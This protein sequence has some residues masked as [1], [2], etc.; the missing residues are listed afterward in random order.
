MSEVIVRGGVIVTVD[1]DSNIVSG[2]VAAIDGE[3]V[4][5][6][7]EYTPR[8]RDYEILDAEG[9]AV[10]PGLVQSHTHLCQTL[11]RGAGDDLAL[12]DWLRK[13]VWPYEASLEAEDLAAAARLACAELLLGGTTAILDMGTVRHTDQVFASCQAAGIRA[14]IG[15]VMMDETTG[16]IP[17]PMRES[18]QAS[19][20]ESIRLC[21]AWHGRANGRLR[22]AFTPRF[23]LSCTEE[24]LRDTAA[25][26]RRRGCRLHTHSSENQSELEEV[27]RRT[28]RRN[29]SY[30]HDVGFTGAD[31]GLAHCIWLDDDET[32][33]LRDTGTHVLHCPSSNLKLGSG[34]APIP[35]L[36]AAGVSVSIGADG[37]PCNNN[38]DAFL[39]M[40]LSALIHKPRA[41]T[42]AMPA[43]LVLK[44]ATLGGARA[45]GLEDSIGS[46]EVGKRAD[47]IA[48]SMQGA[49]VAP[50]EDPYS[51][52]VYAARSADVRHV[53][54]DGAVA[55]RDRELLTID[56]DAVIEEA[57]QRTPHI[58][59]RA[60]TLVASA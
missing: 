46:L 47:L 59:R 60:K 45:L 38:L 52:I 11:A 29:L 58:M 34:I 17:A 6:G 3:L 30:L 2:D 1:P 48:V 20:D 14:T 7:G 21:E 35:E 40:R 27:V 8:T 32:R 33:I 26:A 44:M 55:V 57:R 41:G 39:E 25:E 31:V 36:A 28:G 54:V 16:D 50:S 18:T 43:P 12:L 51:A 15:K 42:R 56:R 19:L 5:V 9:C 10:M 53:V 37:A 22:Y 24:L 49:H 23:V 13:V 4:Q